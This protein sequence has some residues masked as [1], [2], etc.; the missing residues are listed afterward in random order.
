[1]N[2]HI[3]LNLMVA[4]CKVDRICTQPAYPSLQKNNWGFKFL[5]LVQQVEKVHVLVIHGLEGK[6]QD[7]IYKHENSKL[8][9]QTILVSYLDDSWNVTTQL[10]VIQSNPV[11][12]L[13]FMFIIYCDKVDFL[14]YNRLIMQTQAQSFQHSFWCWLDSVI[15]IFQKQD[16]L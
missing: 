12:L 6:K 14:F 2:S 5:V 4:Y 13:I 15:N 16:I 11:N 1:M 7:Y 9:F 3:Y 10:T 8:V